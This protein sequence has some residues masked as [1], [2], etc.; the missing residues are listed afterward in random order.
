MRQPLPQTAGL[1]AGAGTSNLQSRKKKQLK[2][3]PL[4][5]TY[6][7]CCV[8]CCSYELGLYHDTPMH[9]AVLHNTW[10]HTLHKHHTNK[11]RL[12]ALDNRLGLHS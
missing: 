4:R 9:S 6:I 12:D 7:R 11:W 8:A 10:V 5:S 3:R 1:D 2:R